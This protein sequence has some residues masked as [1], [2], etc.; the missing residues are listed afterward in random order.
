[1]ERLETK[2]ER[3][4]GMIT[5]GQVF[6][7]LLLGLI[8]MLG[9]SAWAGYIEDLERSSTPGAYCVGFGLMAPVGARARWNEASLQFQIITTQH[10]HELMEEQIAV[11]GWGDMPNDAIYMV[12]GNNDSANE[13]A[14][15][16][17]IITYGW[18]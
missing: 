8:F 9:S 14:A 6:L 2:M 13:I 4:T 7:V 11:T 12:V 17:A 18:H 16:Q 1:M 5:M 15:Q 3:W 10:Y